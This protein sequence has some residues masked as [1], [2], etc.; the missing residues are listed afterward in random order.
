MFLKT[1][2][3]P[4]AFRIALGRERLR[5]SPARRTAASASLI[6]F[7]IARRRARGAGLARALRAELGCRGRRLARAPTSMS[8]ISPAI[9][10]R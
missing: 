1:Q 5:E 6:A 10:T 8:G 3:L 9:G 4:S 2:T 7:M